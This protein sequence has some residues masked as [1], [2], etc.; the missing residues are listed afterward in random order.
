M[1][2]QI[3]TEPHARGGF[4]IA[5]LFIGA[6]LNLRWRQYMHRFHP[7]AGPRRKIMFRVFMLLWFLGAARSLFI[8]FTT[9]HPSMADIG[10]WLFDGFALVAII[11]A[12]YGIV[13]SQ[14]G[15][16]PRASG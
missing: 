15:W 1:L 3:G 14:K 6:V 2:D 10:Y 5:M 7:P 12:T 9:D 13:S 16:P 11:L 4:H 8:D